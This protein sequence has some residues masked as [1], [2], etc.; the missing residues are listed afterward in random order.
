ML[1]GPFPAWLNWRMN[2]LRFLNLSRNQINGTLQKPFS[3]CDRIEVLCVMHLSAQTAAA[4]TDTTRSNLAPLVQGSLPQPTD[5][6]DARN[7]RLLAQASTRVRKEGNALSSQSTH[8]DDSSPR[9][10]T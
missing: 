6:H 8:L 3:D 7:L 4:V 9:S 2:S 5:G 10:A 1:H